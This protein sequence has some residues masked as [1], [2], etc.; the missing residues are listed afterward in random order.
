[1]FR[2]AQSRVK[3]NKLLQTLFLGWKYK[4]MM[5]KADGQRNKIVKR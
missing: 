1:M 2:H 4:M 5:A 3:E